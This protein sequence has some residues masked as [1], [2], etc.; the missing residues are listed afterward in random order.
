MQTDQYLINHLL[1][2]EGLHDACVVAG[3]VDHHVG[4]ALE[5][6][7]YPQHAQTGVAEHFTGHACLA[8]PD[9]GLELEH[10]LVAPAVVGA[11]D[12]A[13]VLSVQR[14]RHLDFAQRA[15][16]YGHDHVICG[17][18]GCASLDGDLVLLLNDCRHRRIG[19]D[20]LELLDERLGQHRAATG[21]A[22]STQV[23]LVDR[24]INPR[25]LG[26]VQQR[27]ARRLIV[28][29]AD[30]LV[31]QLTRRGRQVQAVQPVGDVDLVQ[32]E[33]GAVGRRV[34]RVVNRAREVVQRVVVALDG[35]GGRRLFDGQVSLGE[36]HTVDQVAGRANKFRRR[37]GRQLE[38]VQ[39]AVQ[40]WLSLGVADPLAGRQ[41]G[42]SAQAGLGFQ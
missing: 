16:R 30:L 3:Q 15:Q 27:Q 5:R 19:L 31:D 14:R 22:R 17:V 38:A 25:L 20:G 33:Q 29:G 36:V 12:R 23:T 1:V 26:E 41:T 37:H 21:Q 35:F 42:T 8:V 11:L 2:A 40:H 4:A 6:G 18:A 9:R 13:H 34:F 28:A 7:L 24:A 39:V 32:R 10:D